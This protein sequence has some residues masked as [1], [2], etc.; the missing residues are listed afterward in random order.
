[1]QVFKIRHRQSG[2]YWNSQIPTLERSHESII[3]L[4]FNTIGFDWTDLD[5][6]KFSIDNLWKKRIKNFIISECEIV[7][8]E[9]KEINK[10]RFYE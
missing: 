9:L 10:I 1:M 7:C 8:F 4:Y 5:R 2:K 6:V 3:N